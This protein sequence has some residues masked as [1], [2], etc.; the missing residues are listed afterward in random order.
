[1]ARERGPHAQVML[2]K[3]LTFM[4]LSGHAVVGLAQYFR[5][6]VAD[7]LIVTDDVNLPLGR[8]RARPA[9]SDGGHNGLRSII[10][11]LGT[12]GVPRLRLGV[13]RGDLRRDLADHVLAGF[14]DAERDV[15]RVAVDRAADAVALFVSD[16]IEP[17]MN[18]F[19]QAEPPPEN[20]ASEDDD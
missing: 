10:E 11:Q 2:A 19:N 12:E 20:D 9:G 16:G 7:V 4:N 13:G 1:M 3:P 5:I 14:D 15:I 17:V 18:R 8:L 6:A